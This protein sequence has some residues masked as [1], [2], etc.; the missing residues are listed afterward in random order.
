MKGWK[1]MMNAWTRSCVS[2]LVAGSVIS[3][4]SAAVMA[5]QQNNAG[6]LP[7]EVESDVSDT[8]TSYVGARILKK[9]TEIFGAYVSPGL[10]QDDEA[11]DIERYG[12]WQGDSLFFGAENPDTG[13]TIDGVAEFYWFESSIPKSSDFYV[14]VLKVK[15]APNVVDDW[16][17]SQED[18]WLGEFMYDIDPCQLVDVQMEDAGAAGAVRWDWS[19]PFQNYKWEPVKTIQMEQSYSAGFDGSAGASASADPA[20]IAAGLVTG[21][22]KEGGFLKD[23]TTKTDIQAKGYMNKKFS[24]SS[25]Y[26]VTLYKWEMTVQGGAD[27]M[28]WNMVVS[29]DGSAAKDSAYHEYF[30]VVQAPQG[31]IARIADI[32]IAANFRHDTTLWFDGWDKLSVS[33]KNIEW[34]PPVD[35]ECYAGDESPEGL[36]SG[37]GVCSDVDAVCAKG[38]WVCVMPETYQEEEYSCDGIDNDCDGDVDEM[39][40]RACSSGCGTGVEVCSFGEWVGCSAPEPTKEICDGLDNNCDGLIDNSEDCYPYVDDYWFDEEEEDDYSDYS[41]DS[42][43]DNNY[44]WGDGG[45]DNGGYDEPNNSNSGGWSPYNNPSG[46]GVDDLL[47]GDGGDND[48]VVVLPAE[49]GCSTTGNGSGTLIGALLVIL[50]LVALRRREAGLV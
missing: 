15:S 33:L 19:V 18:N 5:Q 34:T 24:V 47:K 9:D 25:K 26:S 21:D 37:S 4:S 49:G 16:G 30:I 44:G 7:E 3:L 1:K 45:Y 28:R 11:D 31:E 43:Y 46:A 14:I 29:K 32:N 12:F 39:L 36:C 13:N 8:D 23:L 17:L 40:E 6:A 22:F 38:K 48:Q 41:D 20:K 10:Y 2:V 50:A 35:I 42:D 27:E